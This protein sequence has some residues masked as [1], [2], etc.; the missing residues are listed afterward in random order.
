MFVLLDLLAAFDTVNHDTLTARFQDSFGIGGT[1][2]EWFRSYLSGRSQHVAIGN[3]D[4][5]GALLDMKSLSQGVPQ[6]LVLGPITFTSYTTPLG[7]ICRSHD[8][9][10]Q[11]YADDQQVYLSFK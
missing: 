5:D 6:G 10:F 2:L 7:D 3:P 8:I 11:L 9:L 1:A 4:M